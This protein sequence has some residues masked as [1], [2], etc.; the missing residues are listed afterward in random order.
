MNIETVKA[1]KIKGRKAALIFLS[2]TRLLAFVISGLVFYVISGR[3]ASVPRR[4]VTRSV[5]SR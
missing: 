4:R 3:L 2:C 5:Q 1:K